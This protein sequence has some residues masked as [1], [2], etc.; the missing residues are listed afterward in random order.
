MV[1]IDGENEIDKSSEDQSVG[2]EDEN[3]SSPIPPNNDFTGPT[4]IN[5]VAPLPSASLH[6]SFSTE[7]ITSESAT[8]DRSIQQHGDDRNSNRF[9]RPGA[10]YDSNIAVGQ[11]P[12]WARRRLADSRRN[13][14]WDSQRRFSSEGSN[15]SIPNDSFYSSSV[16]AT[17]VDEEELE[18]A[19]RAD[20]IRTSTAA[21]VVSASDVFVANEQRIDN[22]QCWMYMMALIILVIGVLFALLVTVS[23][24]NNED[25]LGVII[26]PTMSPTLT[27]LPTLA[28]LNMNGIL[29][30]GIVHEET[31]LSVE[32][33]LHSNSM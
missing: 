30:C 5:S 3:I 22:R 23:V 4:S 24:E 21:E 32:T 20:L 29:R 2:A 1:Q 16:V 6:V 26:A 9:L 33:Y 8:I 12:A 18:N 25:D 10:F 13:G 14:I 27:L 7:E 19:V 17:V 31:N 11:I 15:L 28:S